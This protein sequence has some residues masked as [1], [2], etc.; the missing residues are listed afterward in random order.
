MS[1]TG[2]WNQ[3]SDLTFQFLICD[4]W[5]LPR[6]MDPGDRTRQSFGAAAY[7]ILSD[8]KEASTSFKL[9][10]GTAGT[11]EAPPPV[12]SAPPPAAVADAPLTETWQINGYYFVLRAEIVYLRLPVFFINAPAMNKQQGGITFPATVVC[13][14]QVV[15]GYFRRAF[16]IILVTGGQKKKNQHMVEW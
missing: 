9:S 15:P 8:G 3:P 7:F 13:N 12:I 10:F 16:L 5:M 2:G 11:E 6:N 1:G 14:F 4:T